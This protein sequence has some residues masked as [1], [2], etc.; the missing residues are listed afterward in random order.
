MKRTYPAILHEESP[1]FWAEFPDLVG[2]QTQGDTLE[3]IKHNAKE[4]LE[5]Y[6][7]TLRDNG[8]PF[9]K[10]LDNI[11]TDEIIIMITAD[12]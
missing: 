7:L 11:E 12:I 8:E 4:V 5:G 10:A 2:C 6:L 9:P 3:E 1:G